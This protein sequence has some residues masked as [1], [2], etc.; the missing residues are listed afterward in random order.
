MDTVTNPDSVTMSA[1]RRDAVSPRPWQTN[2]YATIMDANGEAIFTPRIPSNGRTMRANAAMLVEA[3][4]ERDSLREE[5]YITRSELRIA[6]HRDEQAGKACRKWDEEYRAI[7]EER[8][9]LRDLVRRLVHQFEGRATYDDEAAIIREALE[10][11]GE[12]TP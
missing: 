1:K 10:A 4:N 2:Q 12:D 8:E 6:V 11:A 5:L 3:V 7:F 9:R